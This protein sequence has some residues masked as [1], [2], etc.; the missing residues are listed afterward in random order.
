M[1]QIFHPSFNTISKVTI[2]GAIFI[3]AGAAFVAAEIQ[4]S[5]Y[6]TQAEVVVTQ[7]V[8]FSHE[9]HVS[10]LGID[11]RYCH[12]TAETSPFAGIPPTETCM[13][14]HSRIWT[15]AQLLQPVRD[16]WDTGKPIK[17]V[18]VHDLPDYVYFDHSIHVNKGV[19]CVTCHGRVDQMPLTYKTESLQ[20]E[21]CL[22]CHREPEKYL[23]PRSQ[24]FNMTWDPENPPKDSNLAPKSQ[25]ELG[26][27]LVSKYKVHKEQI[28]NCSICHR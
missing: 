21:W 25:E 1:A 6:V 28:T 22:E 7:P 17:W 5:P 4:R 19:G 11:C 14:C 16:S 12:T 24:V 13:T 18:R 27:E 8:P 2:F 23:R 15:N 3:V 26:T 9:H 20:M 10:G